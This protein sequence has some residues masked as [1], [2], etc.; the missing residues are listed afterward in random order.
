MLAV[1]RQGPCSSADLEAKGVSRAQVAQVLDLL[2]AFDLVTY[3]VEHQGGRGRPPRSWRLV[4]RRRLDSFEK[5]AAR[6]AGKSDGP[7]E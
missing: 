4:S 5:A 1:L 3:D 2:L 7:Q 6:L